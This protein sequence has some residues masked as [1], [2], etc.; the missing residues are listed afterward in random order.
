MR[1]HYSTV[2]SSNHS[3]P[4]P[5]AIPIAFVQY[6]CIHTNPTYSA[7][8][9]R[10][11]VM[12]ILGNIKCNLMIDVALIAFPIYRVA[13]VVVAK[14]TCFV[15][16]CVYVLHENVMTAPQTCRYRNVQRILLHSL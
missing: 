9:S 12:N 6:K 7:I 14:G 4:Q 11:N 5:L 13:V 3:T 16:T 2:Y 8:V 10:E 15:I 1:S